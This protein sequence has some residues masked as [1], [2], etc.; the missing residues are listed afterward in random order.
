MANVRAPAPRIPARRIIAI[1]SAQYL[2]RA[3]VFTQ[4]SLRSRRCFHRLPATASPGCAQESSSTPQGIENDKMI[5][6]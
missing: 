1:A 3:A 4:A 2:A 6:A 5:F